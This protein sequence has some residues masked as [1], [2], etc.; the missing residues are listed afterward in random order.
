MLREFIYEY[1]VHMIGIVSRFG[2][3]Q[4]RPC[5]TWRVLGVRPGLFVRPGSALPSLNLAPTVSNLI[6]SIGPYIV[7]Y[8]SSA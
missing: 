4:S 5:Q 8:L 3:W 6:F 7:L 2:K 1:I